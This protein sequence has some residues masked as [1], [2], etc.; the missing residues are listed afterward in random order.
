MFF[1]V[2]T[3]KKSQRPR[4]QDSKSE[5]PDIVVVETGVNEVSN[6]NLMRNPLAAAEEVVI[7]LIKVSKSFIKLKPGLKVILLKQVPRMDNAMISKLSSHM[8][9]ILERKVKKEKAKYIKVEDLKIEK[10]EEIFGKKG[11]EGVGGKV[12][13]IHPRGNNGKENFTSKMCNRM[14]QK[15]LLTKLMVITNP[16]P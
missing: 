1:G 15:Q 9:E 2:S 14:F 4:Y 3:E 11:E 5:K 6:I 7:N 16:M 8:N 13:F 12:D 10:N